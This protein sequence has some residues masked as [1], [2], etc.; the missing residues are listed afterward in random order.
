[1]DRRQCGSGQRTQAKRREIG[2]QAAQCGE[3]YQKSG[4]HPCPLHGRLHA[5]KRVDSMRDRRDRPRHRREIRAR[6]VALGVIERTRK[7]S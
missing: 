4:E 3:T 5:G 1:M 6:V 2:A 7:P